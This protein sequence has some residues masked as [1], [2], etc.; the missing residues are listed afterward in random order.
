[1]LAMKTSESHRGSM[2]TTAPVCAVFRRLWKRLVIAASSEPSGG[3]CAALLRAAV[4]D[5]SALPFQAAS[6]GEVRVYPAA[7]IRGD[8]VIVHRDSIVLLHIGATRS[9]Y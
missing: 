3:L 6:F 4:A 5:E 9:S 1:C 7:C 2:A 8:E